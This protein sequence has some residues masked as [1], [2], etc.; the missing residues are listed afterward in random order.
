MAEGKQTFGIA[1]STRRDLLFPGEPPAQF[2]RK[3]MDALLI[4]ASEVG[5]SDITI[6][7]EERVWLKISNRMLRVTRRALSHQE[8][9]DIVA[10]TARSE[11]VKATLAGPKDEDYTYDLRPDRDRRFRFRVNAVGIVTR[12]NMGVEITLRTIP[13]CPPRLEELGVEPEILRAMAPRQGMVV[14]TGETGSGKSTLLASVMRHLMEDPEGDRKI[15]TFESPIE[16]VYDEVDRPSTAVAQTEIPRNLPTFT[17]ATRN[18][19]RRNPSIILVGEARDAETMRESLIAAMTGHALYTT[20]HAEGFPLTVRRMV[21]IFPSEEINSRAVDVITALR[22]SISQTLVPSK[23]GGRVAL[24]E[25]VVMDA[26][27]REELMAA[28]LERLP[29]A[30]LAVLRKRGQSFLQ[31]AERKLEEGLIDESIVKTL[32]F[33]S[34]GV[35]EDAKTIAAGAKSNREVVPDR[36]PTASPR[37]FLDKTQPAQPADPRLDDLLGQGQRP[38]PGEAAPGD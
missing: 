11:A 15:I 26:E 7:T 25:Y 1:A 16:Y 9:M 34:R 22:M 24:R 23:Q 38:G 6:Q 12:G 2:T 35:R 21:S 20:V 18:A 27:S 28:D 30:A 17:A 10:W 3:D 33:A 8:V 37:K 5:A 32:R 13:S 14:V 29:L 31:A 36:A 4:W 19:L